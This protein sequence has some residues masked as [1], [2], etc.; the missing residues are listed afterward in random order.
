MPR[1]YLVR[2]NQGLVAPGLSETVTIM[3]VEKDKKNLLQSYERLGQKALDQS[4]DKFLV[5]SSEVSDE[6]V[7][8]FSDDSS[9]PGGLRVGK[10][11]TDALTEMWSQ[12]SPNRF[13]KKLQVKHIVKDLDALGTIGE[14]VGDLSGSGSLPGGAASLQQSPFQ[15]EDRTPFED[16]THEEM[17]EEATSLRRRYDELVAFS[18]NLTAERDILNN[19]LEQTKRDL[20]REMAARA[21]LENGGMS[22]AAQRKAR[23]AGFT[24]TFTQLFIVA[25]A[26][27]IFGIKTGNSGVVPNIPFI[28]QLLGL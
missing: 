27:Y 8:Q 25:I 20:S 14:N 18:V 12:P 21:T 10:E 24:F 5:Q 19:S 1:R 9:S 26:C 22:K 11:L 3:V 16:M 15:Q 7:S 13:N 17:I 2:P 23:Q 4:K 28:S 6:F